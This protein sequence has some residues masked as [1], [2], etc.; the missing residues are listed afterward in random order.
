MEQIDKISKVPKSIDELKNNWRYLRAKFRVMLLFIFK[1]KSIPIEGRAKLTKNIIAKIEE[2]DRR[3]IKMEEFKF[4]SKGE[5]SALKS[6]AVLV[7]KNAFTATPFTA[8]DE[9]ELKPNQPI[10]SKAIPSSTKGIF[11]G[12]F[13]ECFLLPRKIAPARAATPEDVCT[14]R[15][16]AKSVTPHD[17]NKP[18]GC[19]TM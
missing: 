17:L 14:T 16:P 9:P 13:A 18:S 12:I 6:H 8:S 19:H 1:N 10:Q 2:G 11:T 3:Y 15:P 7:F 4:N 5:T